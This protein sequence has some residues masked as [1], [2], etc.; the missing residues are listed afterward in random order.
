MVSQ[1]HLR[2]RIIFAVRPLKSS[3]VVDS[4]RNWKR[5]WDFLSVISSNL[6]P[7]L[8]RF[9]DA[10]NYRLTIDNFSIPSLIWRAPSGWPLSNF[11]K[12]LK[13]LIQDLSRSRRWRFHYPS[14]IYFDTIQQCDIQSPDRQ[15]DAHTHLCTHAYTDASAMLLCWRPVKRKIKGKQYDFSRWT[16]T[17]LK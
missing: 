5:L 3:K 13:I 9:W 6:G 10:A 8:H 17:V 14:L 2:S 11:A 7:I 12:P 15:T 16:V 1:G 4:G